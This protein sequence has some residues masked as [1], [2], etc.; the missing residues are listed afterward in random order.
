MSPVQK[1]ACFQKL[2]SSDEGFLVLK[3]LAAFA[4]ADEAEY[5]AD[6]RKEA[7]L[8]GRRSVIMEIRRILNSNEKEE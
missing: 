3:E 8:L 7:Y 1:K 6:P 2:F 4:R 5:C